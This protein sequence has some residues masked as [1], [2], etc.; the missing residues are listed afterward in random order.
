VSKRFYK[1]VAA[2]AT[3]GGGHIIALDGRPVR[4]PGKMLLTAPTAALAEAIAGEWAAQEEEILPATMLLMRLAATAI[5]RI[6][7]QRLAIVEQIAAYGGTDLL[8]YRAERPEELVVR[9]VE[10]WQPLLDWVAEAHGARLAV[11]HGIAHTAQ[12]RGALDALRAAVEEQDDFRLAAVSQLTASTGSL[13]IALAVAARRVSAEEAT[14]ASQLDE[15]WQAEKWGHDREAAHR[16]EALA[17]E[18]DA[19]AR[20]LD[21]L[22]APSPVADT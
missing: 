8:C 19:A 18:I 21:L 22:A 15:T 2:T 17:Q 14:A 11:T 1:Q 3:E 9:Q 10:L 16:R 5:D 12:D 6:G 4:T 20:F 13:V 7:K